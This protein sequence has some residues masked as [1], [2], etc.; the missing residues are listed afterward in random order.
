[1]ADG[2]LVLF[3]NTSSFILDVEFLLGWNIFEAHYIVG[4][5]TTCEFNLLAADLVDDLLA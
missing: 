3:H 1:M 2:G 4:A 5:L